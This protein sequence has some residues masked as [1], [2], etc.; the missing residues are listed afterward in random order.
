MLK[1][2]AKLLQGSV[3]TVEGDSYR[4]IFG[5]AL[6]LGAERFPLMT[7]RRV[8]LFQIVDALPD[9]ALSSAVALLTECPFNEVSVTTAVPRSHVQFYVIDDVLFAQ[10]YK[11]LTR[12]DEFAQDIGRLAL[13]H[14]AVAFRC[15]LGLGPMKMHLGELRMPL[16]DE[17]RLR[18]QLGKNPRNFPELSFRTGATKKALGAND[19][20]VDGYYPM[21]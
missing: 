5:G 21:D 17:A 10:C 16:H 9:D 18:R 12:S 8:S 2:L 20:V 4:S 19:L 14:R 15:G 6:V 3:R 11:P 1:L 7:T 13:A